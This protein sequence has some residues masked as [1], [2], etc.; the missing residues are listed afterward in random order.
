MRIKLFFTHFQPFALCFR[1]PTMKIKLCFLVLL[2]VS[3]K[4]FKTE[5]DQIKVRVYSQGNGV[6][7]IDGNFY[8]TVI[9]GEQEW[10]AENLKVTK[11]ND[12]TPIAEYYV[13]MNQDNTPYYTWPK[14]DKSYDSVFGKLYNTRIIEINVCPSGWKIPTK[15]DWIRMID[16]IGS[17]TT[18]GEK[19]K[20]VGTLNNNT[21]LWD[22]DV[23]LSNNETGFNALP[24]GNDS[25]TVNKNAF[26]WNSTMERIPGRKYPPY[27]SY[28]YLKL[29][30]YDSYFTKH[31]VITVYGFSRYSI[32][33][34]KD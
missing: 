26:F 14:N 12:G 11:L 18:I 29:N 6:T 13:G 33:C 34:I 3:C 25:A 20:S 4:K 5:E 32:R 2:L 9:I 21:G 23:N 16:Y 30:S 28:S 8:K 31:D 15:T 10:M 17:F 24:S 7:D 22:S 19:I 27:Y 1:F